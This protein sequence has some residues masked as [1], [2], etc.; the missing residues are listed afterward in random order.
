M[1]AKI[2]GL[3]MVVAVL[4]T[5]GTVRGQV[6]PNCE[7]P[8]MLI[9]LDKSGSMDDYDK[10]E[11]AKSA[12]NTI[13]AAYD[14][15]INFGLMLFPWTGGCDVSNGAIR[16][17]VGPQTGNDIRNAM[18]NAS[19]GG[20]TPMHKALD[21]ALHYPKLNDPTRRNFVMLITDGMEIMA[22][23]FVACRISKPQ[24]SRPLSWGSEKV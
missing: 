1:K 8:N 22:I 4:C 23:R 3:L 12:I 7:M 17:D 16:V 18:N 13:T 14:T 15:K 20:S 2:S 6:N 9:V 21:K 19:P 5:A 24:I 11:N 10:W